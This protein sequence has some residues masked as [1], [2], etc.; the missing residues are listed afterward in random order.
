M[1]LTH[2]SKPVGVLPQKWQLDG[3]NMQVTSTRLF[4][5]LTRFDLNSKMNITFYFSSVWRVYFYSKHKHMSSSK[6]DS[7]ISTKSPTLKNRHQQNE[8]INTKK[9]SPDSA[10]DVLKEQKNCKIMKDNEIPGPKIHPSHLEQIACEH[11]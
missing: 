1:Q 10:E 8:A 9:N 7:E 11:R 5:T 3:S 4:I 2:C 6:Y